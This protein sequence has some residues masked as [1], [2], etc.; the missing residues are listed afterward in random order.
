MT[1]VR[2]GGA[3]YGPAA[4]PHGPPGEVPN[5][6][7]PDD[8]D[9]DAFVAPGVTAPRPRFPAREN[10][11]D[12]GVAAP[13]VLPTRPAWQARGRGEV[14]PA[15]LFDVL[16][17]RRALLLAGL[18][19]GVAIAATY[20]WWA[21]PVYEATASVRVDDRRSP[22]PEVIRTVPGADELNTEVEVIPSRTL[23]AAVS[24]SL[25]LRIDVEAPRQARRGD[26][27]DAARVAPD[28]DTGLVEGVRHADGSVVLSDGRGAV[29]AVP[30]TTVRLGGLALR[31]AP[32]AR[33]VPRFALRVL[34]A[35]AAVARTLDAFSATRSGNRANLM[36]LHYR[37]ADPALARD[38]LNAWTGLYIAQRN[39]EQ[40]LE[41]RGTAT[42]LQAQ[43][44]TL[45]RE[46]TASEGALRDFRER[47]RVVA[48]D[49]EA[50]AA[51]SH[52]A[53]LQTER[54]A[55]DVERRA[56]GGLLDS[57][58][59]AAA[60]AAAAGAAADEPSPW[61][62][63]VG[64]PTLLR[65][66]AVGGLLAS[67]TQ[68][69]QQRSDLSARRSARD[70]EVQTL[71]RRQRALEEQLRATAETY[72]AGLGAQVAGI[73]RELAQSGAALG[74]MPGR[75]QRLAQLQR[76]PRVLDGLVTMLQTRL[77]EA[78][79]AQAVSDPSVRVV[80]LAVLPL[81]PLTPKRGFTLVLGA[82]AGL[83][84]GAALAF[85]RE[86]RGAP[87]MRGEADV[88]AVTPLPV[89][90]VVPRLPAAPPRAAGGLL[91]A[92][93]GG[94]LGGTFGRALRGSGRATRG[95]AQRASSIPAATS[96]EGRRA[97]ARRAERGSRAVVEAVYERLY[98]EAAYPGLGPGP[99]CLLVTSASAGEGKSTT[100]LMLARAMA[101]A[102]Q[103]V[104]L[105]DADLR[106]GGADGSVA[107]L[108]G[109]EGGPGTA[110][111][112]AGAATIERVVH[113]VDAGQR[114][115][116][117]LAAGSAAE[118]PAALFAPVR[119]DVLLGEVE[120]AFDLVVI[121]APPVNAAADAA[122][123]ATR[124]DGVLVVARAGATTLPELAYA[125]ERL[126]R[127]RAPVLG[128]VL[129]EADAALQTVP[130][131]P[132]R[133]GNSA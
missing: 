83:L 89:L 116:Y 115:L 94:A 56:L 76:A 118:R 22:T 9:D 84:A 78:Q 130:P 68:A 64:F 36:V 132:P 70:P 121:D 88:A 86:T 63:L 14:T 25:A 57:L 16:R 1:L 127:V 125:L 13:V 39:A 69:D 112:L 117:L 113:A 26:L 17:R 99:R 77:K 74:R 104:L 90:G 23:A 6:A 47:E 61:R 11:A 93:F 51:V 96:R 58:R 20:L 114:A 108:C 122:M 35:G 123:L 27:L 7:A 5:D 52:A 31:L 43:L 32:G 71:E 98:V 87:V 67:L 91:G 106:R 59:G 80:D 8:E 44:D 55:V 131:S 97:R 37:D 124:A 111:V 40:K 107:D 128:L 92:A 10:A 60:Q 75:E 133:T 54:D 105:V 103:V 82:V 72:V 73:D 38:V 21:V 3:P 41:A 45:G 79:V 129:N 29:R 50:S 95:A 15:T 28:A 49:E 66:P 18:L 109:V 42:F 100:A 19:L 85:A 110:D 2:Y 33:D 12:T 48:P 120:R 101:R 65:N 81:R 119:L 126:G 102:G 4:E 62:R 30:G 46:L 53:A 34:P 24:D